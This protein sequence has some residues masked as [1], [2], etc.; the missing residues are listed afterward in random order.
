M[1]AKNGKL[2]EEKSRQIREI[3]A[4]GEYLKEL[5]RYLGGTILQEAKSTLLVT[6]TNE[7]KKSA[8]IW[9]NNCWNKIVL[10]KQ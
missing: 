8:E 5:N 4:S 7:Q 9:Q 2:E 10:F 3:K 6:R 1:A